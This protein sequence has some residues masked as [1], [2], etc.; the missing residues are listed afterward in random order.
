M[1]VYMLYFSNL[2]KLIFHKYIIGQFIFYTEYFKKVFK[3]SNNN[4]LK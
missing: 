3:R 2:I 1:K 4:S